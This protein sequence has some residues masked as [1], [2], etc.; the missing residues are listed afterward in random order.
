MSDELHND[1]HMR[2]RD[3]AS[4]SLLFAALEKSFPHFHGKSFHT[5]VDDGGKAKREK[6]FHALK[7]FST[8]FP[9]SPVD[10]ESH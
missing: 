9:Q 1:F 4:I 10:E 8:S 6:V 5:A 3:F 2:F 7:A